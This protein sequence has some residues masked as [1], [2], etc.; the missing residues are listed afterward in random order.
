[1]NDIG[2]SGGGEVAVTGETLKEKSLII[3]PKIS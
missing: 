3:I 2:S 1:L